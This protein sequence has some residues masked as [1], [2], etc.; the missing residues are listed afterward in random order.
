MLGLELRLELGLEVIDC[1]DVEVLYAV[2]RCRAAD[3]ELWSRPTAV[4]PA[5][6]ATDGTS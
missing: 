5:S 4:A 1:G 2:C 6:T 3:V